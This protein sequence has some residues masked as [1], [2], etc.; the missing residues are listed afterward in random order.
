VYLS[1]DQVEQALAT[2]A[3]GSF[4]G[5]TT[6]ISLPNKTWEGRQCSAVRLGSATYPGKPTIF[7]LGCLHAREWGSPDILISFIEQLQDAYAANT[8]ITIGPAT[9]AAADLKTLVEN[10]DIIV[11]PQ[12]N[13]DGRNYSMTQDN[14]TTETN[15]DMM[16]RKN[17]RTQAPNSGVGDCVGVDLNRNF[18][19][20]WDFPKYFAPSGQTGI[21]DST[22]PCDHDLYNGPAAF[23]EPETQ[24]V[25]WIFDNFTNVGFF[26]DLHSYSG[27][28]MYAWGDDQDQS[29][30]PS[31]N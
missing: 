13:P 16:W 24:N 10:F 15:T 19:F 5:F 12:A 1:V 27:L 9:Y 6:L 4:S 8:G 2:A 20:L 17:R 25:K 18:D 21:E 11:F 28:V 31:M 14:P 26:M 23:S 30:N 7:L 22:N 29:T 3:S